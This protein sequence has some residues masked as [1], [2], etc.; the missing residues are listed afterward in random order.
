MEMTLS[1]LR[2][3]GRPLGW[4]RHL[5]P[6]WPIS[7]PWRWQRVRRRWQGGEGFPSRRFRS[8]IGPGEVQQGPADAKVGRK[9]RGVQDQWV[10]VTHP[11]DC[12]SILKNLVRSLSTH[13]WMDPDLDLLDLT[14]DPAA[15]A[16][17][18]ASPPFPPSPDPERGG[19]CCC[20]WVFFCPL[21]VRR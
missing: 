17:S 7:R 6:V 14:M 12:C 4:R 5:P 1:L 18:A 19:C 16:E 8:C 20:C 21:T 9:G 2:R 15:A 3:R 13:G 11:A 10:G